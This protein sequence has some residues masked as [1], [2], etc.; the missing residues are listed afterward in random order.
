[1]EEWK[2]IPGYEGKYQASTF[3]RIKSL[4]RV[5]YGPKGGRTTVK[6]KI[7]KQIQTSS[8]NHYL[9]VT[10]RRADEKGFKNR[11]VHNL[12]LNT[13]VGSCPE[14]M[15]CCH[16]PDRNP[17]NNAIWNI[18]W[19]TPKAN[20]ADRDYHGMTARGWKLAA[21]KTGTEIRWA[22]IDLHDR[23]G[24]LPEKLARIFARDVKTIEYLIY[25]RPDRNE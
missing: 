11:L 14:G 3:G 21:G 2:D 22:I 15:E 12:V 16:S 25:H 18:R 23:C 4:A 7:L 9:V 10:I 20:A 13:F 5:G 24:Y 6:E 19:D 1:M 8:T 17:H